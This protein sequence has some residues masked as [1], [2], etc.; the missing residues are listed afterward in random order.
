MINLNFVVSQLHTEKRNNFNSLFSRRYCLFCNIVDRRRVSQP[1][2][3]KDDSPDVLQRRTAFYLE[4]ES[5]FLVQFLRSV[6]RRFVLRNL[7]TNVL[8]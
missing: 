5:A 3:L 8:L 6:F 2:L 1:S 7:S 4:S